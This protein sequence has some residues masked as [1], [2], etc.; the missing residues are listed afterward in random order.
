MAYVAT[1]DVYIATF[2]CHD[3]WHMFLQ[4]IRLSTHVAYVAKDDSSLATFVAY[5]ATADAYI[6]TFVRHNMWNIL[7]Q[8][9]SL[10]QHMTYVA[11]DIYM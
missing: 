2:F 6:S 8:M 3:M 7:V 5:V 4:M 1:A 9:I 11:T 10:S